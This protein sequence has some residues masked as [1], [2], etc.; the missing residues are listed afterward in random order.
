MEKESAIYRS[1]KIPKNLVGNEDLAQLKEEM[2]AQADRDFDL[3][4]DYD[5][6]NSEVNAFER[7]N[8]RIFVDKLKE[9]LDYIMNARSSVEID[10]RIQEFASNF[11][12]GMSKT[13][14]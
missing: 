9:K 7:E 2:K 12:H 8:A 13:K 3:D 5:P 6:E 1:E 14:S 4:D 10:A 11:C